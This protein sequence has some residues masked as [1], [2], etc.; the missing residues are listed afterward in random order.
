LRKRDWLLLSI[1]DRMEPIQIQKTLFK[2]AMESD[3]PNEEKYDFVPYN[4]GPCSFDIYPDLERLRAEGLIELEASGRGWDAYKPTTQGLEQMDKLRQ[5]A[6]ANVLLEIDAA[7]EYVRS[8][9]FKKLLSDVYKQ[10]PDFATKS[11]FR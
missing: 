7:R 10:Y 8:R 3:A 6:S 11:L 4:W 9:G 5:T 1:T 2:F